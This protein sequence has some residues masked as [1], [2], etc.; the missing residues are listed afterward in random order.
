VLPDPPPGSS[1]PLRSFVRVLGIRR[2]SFVELSFAHGDPALSVELV[3]PYGAFAE[4]CRHYQVET[5]E[6]EPGVALA[7]DELRR[8]SCP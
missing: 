4:L 8:R 7:L 2:S 5:I 1:G 3:L 6:S